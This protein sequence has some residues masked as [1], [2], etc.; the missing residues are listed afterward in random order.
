MGPAM[1][2]A[3]GD[4]GDADHDHAFALVS[5][6]EPL[7]A[8]LGAANGEH[9]RWYRAVARALQKR[10][11]AKVLHARIGTKG[12]V[13]EARRIVGEADVIYATGGDVGLF[14]DRVVGSG[15]DEVVRER[16]RAGA[17]LVGVSAGAIGLTAYWVRFPEDDPSLRQPTRF[18]CAGALRIAVDCHDEA[19][20]WE[21]LR[22][23]LA[24]WAREAPD[25]VVD[26]YGIPAGAALFL[27]GHGAVMTR[28]GPP[29]RLRLE[30]GRVF[31]VPGA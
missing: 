16:H 31:E 8:Y 13:A 23:L 26:G 17:L 25:D 20:D 3:N 21:E 6:P 4:P 2:S 9:T 18:P 11:G 30:R 19:S 12:D 14:A 5:R 10:Y 28:G 24:A 15:L 27:D 7:V 1:L 22:A 29:L